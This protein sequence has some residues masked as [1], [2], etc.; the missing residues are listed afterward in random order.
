[1]Q[2][3]V[4]G[5]GYVGLVA[6]TCLAELGHKVVCVDS[7]SAKIAALNAGETL[8]HEDYLQELLSRHRG[9]R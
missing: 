2:I 7:D 9:N 4:I 5:S 1:M 6:A 8:I 3:S